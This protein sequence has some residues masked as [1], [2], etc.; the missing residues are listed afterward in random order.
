V[1][2]HISYSGYPATEVKKQNRLLKAGSPS[3]NRTEV[4]IHWGEWQ[5]LSTTKIFLVRRVVGLMETCIMILLRSLV[6]L[7]HWS[8]Q[9]CVV[10]LSLG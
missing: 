7:Q 1:N 4:H 3:S 5:K 10:C 9:F 8:W 6:Q 2:T